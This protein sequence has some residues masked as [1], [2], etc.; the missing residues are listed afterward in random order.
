M[1]YFFRTGEFRQFEKLFDQYCNE[2]D[3]VTN[4]EYITFDQFSKICYETEKFSRS[5]LPSILTKINSQLKEKAKYKEENIN[6]KKSEYF[7]LM[8]TVERENDK[9]ENEKDNELFEIFNTFASDQILL[10]SKLI[11]ILKSFGLPI[12]IDLFLSQVK[13]KEELTFSDFCGLFNK[14]IESDCIL[15]NSLYSSFYNS[16]FLHKEYSKDQDFPIKFNS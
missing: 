14:K 15:L 11:E 9:I 10:K 5:L 8:E 2:K 12:S 3:K 7:T 4:E 6:I 1:N 16:N 13:K